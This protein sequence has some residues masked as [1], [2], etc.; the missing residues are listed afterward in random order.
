MYTVLYTDMYEGASFLIR[1]DIL[2]VIHVSN[3]LSDSVV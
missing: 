2:F 3:L 1:K